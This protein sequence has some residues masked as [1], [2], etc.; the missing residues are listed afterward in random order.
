MQAAEDPVRFGEEQLRRERLLDLEGR[1]RPYRLAAFAVLGL[2]LLASGPW[3]GWWW[4]IP[5][6]GALGAFSV[7]DRLRGRSAMP[8]RWVAASWAVSPLMIATSVALTGGLHS[9][10]I[11]WFALP[12]VTLASRFEV[13]GTIVGLAYSIALM[14]ASTVPFDPSGAIADPVP[15]IQTSA[16]ILAIAVLGGAIVQSDRD[17]RR[18]AVL[19]PLTGLF[20]RSALN[21][22]FTEQRKSST[23]AVGERVGLLVGDLDHFKLINDGHGHIVGDSVLKDVSYLLRKHLRALDIVYRVGG[24]EFVA[25]LPGADLESTEDAA[26][27][28]RG[29]IEEARPAGLY[30]SISFGAVVAEGVECRDFDGLYRRADAALYEAKQSGRNS[31]RIAGP[32]SASP[33]GEPL[34]ALARS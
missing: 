15:L 19:D 1:L 29:A 20:N 12:V 5:L 16:L 21:Q 11:G 34:P 13:R 17:H 33:A 25:L 31:V 7:G 14:L 2:A 9:A 32:V 26:E 6:A 18:E 3:Q 28:L 30:V 27:R 8:E 4:L 24:E 22:R 10:A 23:D